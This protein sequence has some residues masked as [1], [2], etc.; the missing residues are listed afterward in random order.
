MCLI[1][2]FEQRINL[3]EDSFSTEVKPNS[4]VSTWWRN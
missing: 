3:D 4:A 1:S 2:A